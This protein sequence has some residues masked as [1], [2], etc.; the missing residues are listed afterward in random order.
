MSKKECVCVIEIIII[1]IIPTYS[2]WKAKRW[3]RHHRYPRY[4]PWQRE[5]YTWS[6]GQD[7]KRPW[8]KGQHLIWQ[9]RKRLRDLTKWCCY[10]PGTIWY[11]TQQGIG[12]CV[13]YTRCVW[14]M[15]TMYVVLTAKYDGS[16]TA[17]G[18]K[19][20]S[21]NG[22][23]YTAIKVWQR[24]FL[25]ALNLMTMMPCMGTHTHSC[26]PMSLTNIPLC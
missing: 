25:F 13:V 11:P 15:D 19:E 14:A 3:R 6:R 17:H 16:S 10:I 26:C 4:Q 1:I 18:A 2:H 20:R 7:A 12:A 21:I 5:Q 23:L 9:C 24:Q 8:R 22:T